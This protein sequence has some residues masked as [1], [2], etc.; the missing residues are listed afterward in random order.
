[1]AALYYQSAIG[2]VINIGRL[3][4]V[5]VRRPV[6][7]RGPGRAPWFSGQWVPARVRFA[8]LAGM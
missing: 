7:R 2:W 4:R 1:L 6:P 5:Y 3:Q 8:L